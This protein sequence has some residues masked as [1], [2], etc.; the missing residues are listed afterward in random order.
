M[1]CVLL[2]C[3]LAFAAV[4]CGSQSACLPAI[5]GASACV[6]GTFI[7]ASTTDPICLSQGSPVCRAPHS[8]NCYMCS[9]TG[10]DFADNCTLT[11]PQQTA[12]CVH[13]CDNC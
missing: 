3:A 4:G 5:P 12:E 10:A 7:D 11:S 9:T 6:A 8:A 1:R 2:V 13:S